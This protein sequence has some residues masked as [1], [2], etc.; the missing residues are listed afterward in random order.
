M[1]VLKSNETADA[2]NIVKSISYIGIL[3]Y[4]SLTYF[5]GNKTS[6]LIE[7]HF[8]FTVSTKIFI[9]KWNHR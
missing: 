3:R 4:I 8:L 6:A 5:N 1:H 2:L 9:E 7:L